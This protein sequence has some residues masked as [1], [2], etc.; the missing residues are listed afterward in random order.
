MT[1]D[2]NNTEEVLATLNGVEG[3]KARHRKLP[4]NTGHPQGIIE[5]DLVGFN[6]EAEPNLDGFLVFS[7]TAMWVDAESW[8]ASVGMKPGGKAK[9][10]TDEP[11]I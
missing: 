1:W 6:V 4:G 10:E 11:G 7:T 3:C 5:V 9:I 8:E 2:G